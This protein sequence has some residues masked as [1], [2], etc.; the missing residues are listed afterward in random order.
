MSRLLT[1]L[2]VVL[3]AA[4]HGCGDGATEGTDGTPAACPPPGRMVGDSCLAPGVADD[5][6]P[7]ATLG[8]GDGSCHPAGMHPEDCVAGFEHLPFEVA[9]A[10]PLA[11]AG[12]C[13]PIL[14]PAPCAPGQLAVPGAGTCHEV[15]DCGSGSWG[16][17]P[18]DGSTHYVDQSFTG[19]SDGSSQAPWTTITAAIDAVP[20]GGLIAIAAGS[21]PEDVVVQGKAVRLWGRCPAQTEVAGTGTAARVMA[22][23]TGAA[24]TEVRGL[25]I[26]GSAVGILVNGAE[27]VVLDQ[28]WVHDTAGRGVVVDST[29]GPTS[30]TLRGSLVEGARGVGVFVA[31]A[32]VT[33]EQTNVRATQPLGNDPGRGLQLQYDES[34][35]APATVLLRGSLVEQNHDLGVFIASSTVTVEGTVIRHTQPHGGSHGMGIGI[36]PNYATGEPSTATLRGS[37][38]EGN[39]QLGVHVAGADVTVA[40]TVIRG[41][42]PSGLGAGWGIGVEP[43]HVSL[44]ASQLSVTRSVVDG[45]QDCG[46]GILGSEA[47]VDQ[48]VVVGT[49]PDHLGRF[50]RGVAVQP[51]PNTAAPAVVTVGGSLVEGSHDAGIFIAGSNVTVESTVVRGT[52][53]ST[54]G[55]GRGLVIQ[56]DPGSL[57]PSVVTLRSLVAADNHAIGLLVSSSQVTLGASQVHRTLPGEADLLGD[58]IVLVTAAG[59]SAAELFVDHSEIADS[60][61]AGLANF[62][63]FASL[64]GTTIQCA[65]F[66]LEGEPY[67]G[68]AYQTEDRGGNVCGCPKPADK[69]LS[70][71]AGLEP[72]EPI[73]AVY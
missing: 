1:G 57:A 21:Y 47:T 66:E 72:P 36:E 38:I 70:V 6:C 25:A 14:P 68:K 64:A 40:A 5:G 28:L 7:A 54:T 48:T 61:R 60:A 55:S 58:G 34:S 8:S 15:M 4:L 3:S 26:R 39:H 71:S 65:A 62:G 9:A 37:W 32:E 42:L 43:N 53:A 29:S 20:A 67:E 56:P 35:Y 19:V 12:Q 59:F 31:A 17:I 51:N 44:A 24:S 69:C 50:G 52:L 41:T 49:L 63:A 10:D 23:R 13:V 33:V 22:I 27:D 11:G 30:V 46:L 2:A 45:N 16:D 73:D 18:V